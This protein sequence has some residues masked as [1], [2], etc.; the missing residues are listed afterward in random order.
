MTRERY[1]ALAVSP[2]EG[3]E[4]VRAGAGTAF[5]PTVVDAFLEVVEP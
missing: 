1:H 3:I 2:R 5:D 4:M